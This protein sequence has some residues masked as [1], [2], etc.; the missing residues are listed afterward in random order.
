MLKF[1]SAAFSRIQYRRII[2]LLAL[3]ETLHN[4]EE[5]LWLPS[6]TLSHNRQAMQT[7]PFEFRIAVAAVTLLVYWI[8]YY[9]ARH[10][11]MPSKC[12]LGGTIVIVLVNVFIPH[13][14]ASLATS[15]YVPGTL[16]GIVLNLPASLY[17]IRRGLNEKVFT[18]KILI[19]GTLISFVIMISLML[20]SFFSA[21]LIE[22]LM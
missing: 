2:W 12:L 5:A 18:L 9:Y 7:T 11:T 8:I 3:T 13:I 20:A 21:G 15:S 6:W 22:R 14:A 16:S 1:F 4:I 17:L 10:G 19:C